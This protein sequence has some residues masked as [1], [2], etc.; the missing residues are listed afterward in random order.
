MTD[1]NERKRLRGT[2][3]LIAVS[4]PMKLVVKDKS[5]EWNPSLEQINRLTY[6]YIKLNRVSGFIDGNIRPFAMFVGFD[7]SLVIPALREFSAPD[8]ALQIFNR[9]FFEMLVGGVYTEAAGA[10]DI[11]R[12]LLLE[13]GY[14]RML[15]RK[16]L[17]AALHASLRE[18]SASTMDSIVLFGQKP[19]T[20]EELQ[21]AMLRG[22]GILEQCHGVSPEIALAGT[23]HYVAGALPE[24]LTCLWTSVEQLISRIWR[25]EVEANVDADAIPSRGNFLKDY[26]VWTT[27]ARIE[28]LYQKSLL[29]TD[30]YRLLNRARKARNEFIHSGSQPKLDDVTAALTALFHLLSACASEY[31]RTELLDDVCTNIV[32][33]CLRRP[34][35]DDERIEPTCWRAIVP[36]PGEDDFKGQYDPFELN[37][38]PIDSFAPAP[39][40]EP[41]R[42]GSRGRKSRK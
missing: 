39:T 12:G 1:K 30:T 34:R 33:R 13:S 37:L 9:V 6:D 19:I 7:G 38:K 41:A 23:T 28:L 25:L 29:H 35:G 15:D 24:A 22:R 11:C 17:N 8:K 18:G 42:S 27:S 3:V 2:P 21:V 36:L 32:K 5:E 40:P 14:T 10:A 31:K 20:I 26:R 16:S 4:A